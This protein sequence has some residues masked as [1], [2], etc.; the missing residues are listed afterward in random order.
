MPKYNIEP[1]DVTCMTN[2]IHLTLSSVLAH[3]V[4]KLSDLLRTLAVE[5]ICNSAGVYTTFFRVLEL[6][7]FIP[8]LAL[9]P[10]LKG[11]TI[12]ALCRPSF[13]AAG[14]E[15][16]LSRQYKFDNTER[17]FITVT[18]LPNLTE[19]FKDMIAQG[20]HPVTDVTMDVPADR[21]INLT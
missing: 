3:F 20:Y 5:H 2:T 16:R 19:Y 11:E 8:N 17:L 15:L 21:Q 12:F 13:L 9:R 10:R 7:D 4:T 1:P 6:D 14:W 18:T